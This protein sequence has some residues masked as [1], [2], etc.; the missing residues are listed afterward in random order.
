MKKNIQGVKTDS[1]AI[2]NG[3]REQASEAYKAAVPKLVSEEEYKTIQ[4]SLHAVQY[5]SS[6]AY[7]VTTSLRA[8]GQAITA[9]EATKNEFMD[10]INRIGKVIFQK[11][12]YTN[13]LKK[14]KK[15]LMEWGDSVEEF[16]V[17]IAEAVDYSW[18]DADDSIATEENPFKRTQSRVKTYFHKINS[19][20][21]WPGTVSDVEINKAFISADGVF[22]LIQSIVESLYNGYEVYE[23]ET[24]KATLG[25][26][27][28]A[29][30]ITTIDVDAPTTDETR[31]ALVQKARE[32]YLKFGMPSR[33]YN[34]AGFMQVT[35]DSRIHILYTAELAANMDVN[36]LASAFN[37]DKTTFLGQSTIIDEFDERM[38]G[39][40]IV[41]MDENFYQI[42]DRLFR[43]TSIYNP[44]QLYYNYDL[45]VHQIYSYSELVNVVCLKTADVVEG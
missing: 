1:K 6:S 38:A 40:Q 35:P 23:W 4:S 13:K 30:A 33:A 41:I 37:M 5:A 28:E 7:N 15:G 32:L 17:D 24:T 3:I 36:V 11:M 44:R 45:H 42:Y 25:D 22:N 29:G 27:F 31:K 34:K 10:A 9:Y 39:A 19:E 2:L 14:F 26:A 12:T 43:L 16:M 8:V 21:R 20:K 18:L